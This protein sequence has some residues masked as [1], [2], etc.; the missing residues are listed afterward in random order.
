MNRS[1]RLHLVIILAV[2]GSVSA[3]EM[4]DMKIFGGKSMQQGK[5]RVEPLESSMPQMIEMMGK[6]MTVCSDGAFKLG[7]QE[8]A[9]AACAFNVVED[10]SARAV[11]DVTCDGQT[12][13]STI[14]RESA[15]EYLV[16]VNASY[17]NRPFHMKARYHYEGTC[18]AKTA[19]AV[20]MDSNSPACQQLNAMR[21]ML[22]PARI[23]G[24]MGGTERQVCEERLGGQLKQAEQ[25]CGAQ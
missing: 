19:P 23:C 5:W 16:D 10:T 6:G 11:L 12:S 9:G 7:R 22:D 24:A 1:N 17:E 21:S 2:A 3:Q 15:S 4:P 20:Q 8:Q 14:T 25:M 18:D 13:R